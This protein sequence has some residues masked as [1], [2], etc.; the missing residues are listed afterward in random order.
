[1]I[2]R[3]DNQ[4]MKIWFIQNTK[5]KTLNEMKGLWTEPEQSETDPLIPLKYK[6]MWPSLLNSGIYLFW[7][8]QNKTIREDIG[9]TLYDFRF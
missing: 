2:L 1:M 5:Y 8:P 4:A 9:Q 6:I 3:Y 7:V